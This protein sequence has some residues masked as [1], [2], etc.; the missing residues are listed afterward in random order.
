MTPKELENYEILTFPHFYNLMM[1]DK[2]DQLEYLFNS[3]IYGIYCFN[4]NK[5][6]FQEAYCLYTNFESDILD[7]I[8]H[9]FEWS[10]EINHNYNLYGLEGFAFVIIHI[11]P[12]WVDFNLRKQELVKLKKDW[13]YEL[14]KEIA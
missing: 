13:P 10:P 9:L 5:I 14:Y 1:E 4:E 11:G 3:G 8:G 6:L 7:I 12:E 2:E